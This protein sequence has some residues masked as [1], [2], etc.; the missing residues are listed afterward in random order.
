MLTVAQVVVFATLILTLGLFVWGKLRYDVVGMLALLVL[1]V[2]GVVPSSQAFSG[3][4]EPAVVT[5]AAVL[6][7]SR[8]LEKSGMVALLVSLLGRVGQQLPVQLLALC[9]MV[10]L[11]SSFMNNV[12]A[13][14]LMIPVAMKLARQSRHSASLLLMPL[15]FASLLGGMTTL[16]GTP[17]N[18]IISNQRLELL[19][20]SFRMFSYS[21]V[22]LSVAVVGILYLAF[23]GWRFLPRRGKSVDQLSRFAEYMTEV[24]LPEGSTLDGQAI[25]T[26]GSK[27]LQVI[28]LIRQDE[29]K[30]EHQVILPSVKMR[31]ADILIV[32]A[33]MEDLAEL[34]SKGDLALVGN[35]KVEAEQLAADDIALV[36]VVLTNLSPAIRQ[37]VA[38]LKLRQRFGLNLLA[39]SRQGQRL[40]LR[41]S[42][43]KFKSGDVL[44]LQGSQESIQ[45]VLQD[46]KC[47]P[48]RERELQLNA[49]NAKNMLITTGLFGLAITISSFAIMPTTISF[50][51]V[52]LIMVLLKI[53]NLREVYESIEFPIIVLLATLIPVG[54]ALSTTGAATLIADG[55]L[56]LSAAWPVALTLA[57]VMAVVMTLSDIINNAAA[58]LITAPIVIRL[59]EGLNSNPDAFLVA[60]ALAASSAFLTPIG[61]QSNTLVLGPGGYKFGDYW[62]VGLPLEIVVIV[63]GVPAI[64]LFWGV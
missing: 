3:F 42:N 56:N 32:E 50:S 24:R 21:S 63:V 2:A 5:V 41:L 4:A 45:A 23:V 58:A 11:L 52:A 44:L 20:E 60:V 57:F 35:E 6:V 43:I 15:A 34:I 22:G 27:G 64:M 54:N 40:S 61:H 19:G 53:I 39:V 25:K 9:G 29:A 12:G 13:M 62:K 17:P 33:D 37:S 31:V 46:L 47:L 59:A 26:L 7:I 49:F 30:R 36:E 8:A 48:L 55:L 51:L 28:S 1:V 16:I 18:L 38:D 10:A 14:A